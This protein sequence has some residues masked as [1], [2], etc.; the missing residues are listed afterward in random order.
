M[1]ASEVGQAVRARILSPEQPAEPELKPPEAVDLAG[2]SPDVA[3]LVGELRQARHAL[4]H[5]DPTHFQPWREPVRRLQLAERLPACQGDS[6]L[7]QRVHE[8][9]VMAAG[10]H[11]YYL[12]ANIKTS[13]NLRTVLEA[14]T[15]LE[16]RLT[17]PVAVAS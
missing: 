1:A 7:R 2:L 9:A 3:T 11:G 6:D 16:A 8:L 13:A 14:I 4:M 17:A 5:P 10:A 15:A 12:D